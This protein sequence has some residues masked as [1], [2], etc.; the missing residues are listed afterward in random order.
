MPRRHCVFLDS[1][2]LLRLQKP[3]F[4]NF[5]PVRLL[6][7]A[8]EFLRLQLVLTSERFHR[9]TRLPDWLGWIII[10]LRHHLS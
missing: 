8:D 5:L 3:S 6:G 2:F 4:F 1:N 7:L 9:L 10:T